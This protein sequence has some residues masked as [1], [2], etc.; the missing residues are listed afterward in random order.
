MV[1]DEP[2]PLHHIRNFLGFLW[3]YR[4]VSSCWCAVF[5]LNSKDIWVLY[6]YVKCSLVPK[7][8]CPSICEGWPSFVV[9]LVQ[10]NGCWIFHWS[11]RQKCVSSKLLTWN[12]DLYTYKGT[13][14][15]NFNVHHGIWCQ[16]SNVGDNSDTQFLERELSAVFWI[17]PAPIWCCMH[18]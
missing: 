16:T 7:S 6:L 15:Y 5:V 10:F 11:C 1:T 14:Y 3:D 13:V 17:V 4:Q 2:I 12:A 18:A 9:L 8:Y